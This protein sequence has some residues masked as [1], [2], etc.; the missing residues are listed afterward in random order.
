MRAILFAL[1]FLAPS[2]ALDCCTAQA[3]KEVVPI[4]NK[5]SRDLQ[6]GM[7]IKI[8]SGEDVEPKPIQYWIN[9][10]SDFETWQLISCISLL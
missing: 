6:F 2:L 3:S 5:G 8:K 1:F 7:K 9:D 10:L 4:S